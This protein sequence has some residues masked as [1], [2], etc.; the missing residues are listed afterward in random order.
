MAEL[1]Q[2][3]L[4]AISEDYPVLAFPAN[5]FGGNGHVQGYYDRHDAL[6]Q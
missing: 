2:I 4:A 1:I 3:N 6:G 5:H